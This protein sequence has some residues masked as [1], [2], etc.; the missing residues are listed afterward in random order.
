MFPS[1]ADGDVGELLELPQGCQGHSRGSG[2]KVGFLSRHHSGKGYQLA[3]QLDSP[4][5]SRVAAGLLSSLDGD[6][7]DLL[8]GPQG[9][10]VSKGVVRAPRNSSAVTAWAEVLICS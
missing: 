1:S 9:G 5:F 7:R 3:R 10:P 2:G 6:L 4:G 8:V